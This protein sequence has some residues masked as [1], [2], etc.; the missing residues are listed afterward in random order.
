VRIADAKIIEALLGE[1]LT[2]WRDVADIGVGYKRGPALVGE[3]PPNA[4]LGERTCPNAGVAAVNIAVATSSLMICT[5][6]SGCVKT[7]LAE[8]DIPPNRQLITNP[9]VNK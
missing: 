9:K 7:E 8:G 5:T 6:S 1:Q 4:S 2:S 3:V